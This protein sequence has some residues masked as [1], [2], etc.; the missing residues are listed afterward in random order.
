[1]KKGKFI[2]KQ[3]N[4]KSAGFVVPEN[5]FSNTTERLIS[6]ANKKNEGMNAVNGFLIPPAY[7]E[8]KKIAMIASVNK[9][10]KTLNFYAIYSLAGIAAV[11]IAVLSFTFWPTKN[12]TPVDTGFKQLSDSEI[13]EHLSSHDI[14]EELLCDAGW[15]QELKDL[16]QPNHIENYLLETD[17]LEYLNETL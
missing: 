14:N 5:Y 17:E 8:N 10:Q 13:I 3:M 4:Q 6:I 2:K 9:N 1:M 12:M 15:C 11:L 7:F 16:H